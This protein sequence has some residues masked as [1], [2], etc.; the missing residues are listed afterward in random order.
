MGSPEKK[1]TTVCGDI[2]PEN[3][4]V[5][6]LHEHTFLDM[7][8]AGKYLK[9]YFKSAPAEMLAF[10]P[11][12]Y[13]F[14]KTGVYLASDDC[15]VT[16]DLDYL[17]REYAFFQAD[18]GQSVCDLSP[19]GVR[20]D[21]LKMRALSERTGLNILCATGIY[22]MTS[23]PPELL[24]KNDAEYYRIFLREVE[25]GINGTDVRPGMLKAAIA[26]YGP[27]GKLMD[28]ELAGV[29]AIARLSA[30]T[31]LSLHIHTDPVIRDE[32]LIET[33]KLAIA[34]G[35]APD[36]VHM[37]HLDNRIA[38]D[39]PVDAYLTK[40]ETDRTLKLDVHKALLDLGITIGLDTWG[41]PVTN[42]AFFMPDD[43]ERLKAL[44]TLIDLG[45][46]DQLTIGCDFSS[47]IMGRTYGGFGCTRFME[48]AVP[49]LKK[50]GYEGSLQK[51]LI[52]NPAKI[53]AY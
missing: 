40:P 11:E 7:R 23:R 49:M 18:G 53:L 44:I 27:D 32:D 41:M 28:G 6:S 30:E 21:V 5:T 31:G 37:C 38:K 24:G 16:D 8:I 48:F 14:L 17:V 10:K 25:E 35:A 34:C 29:R 51:I 47:K 52:D 3:L 22:T 15:A 12:N 45:Y 4:G 19:I 9:G 42:N 13:A 43:F 39:V 2:A 26:T 20:G 46:G 36:K 1:I 50:M 33:A